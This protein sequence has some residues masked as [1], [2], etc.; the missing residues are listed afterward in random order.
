MQQ[1]FKGFFLGLPHLPVS[2]GLQHWVPFYMQ[3]E[4]S[5]IIHLGFVS[6]MDFIIVEM[7]V[8]IYLSQVMTNKRK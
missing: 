5:H 6:K 2:V 1:F 7:Y 3:V 4:H 8:I